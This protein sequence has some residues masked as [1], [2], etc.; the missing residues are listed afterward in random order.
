MALK[1]KGNDQDEQFLALA[2]VNSMS[3]GQESE[4]MDIILPALNRDS[5]K[6]LQTRIKSSIRPAFLDGL[7]GPSSEEESDEDEEDDDEEE[8]FPIAKRLRAVGA[9]LAPKVAETFDCEEVKDPEF[10]KNDEFKTKLRGLVRT[11]F[12][13]LRSEMMS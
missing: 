7:P 12:M 3:K 10:F 11:V 4:S 9:K 6:G 5:I 13:E 2:L 1:P 8:E